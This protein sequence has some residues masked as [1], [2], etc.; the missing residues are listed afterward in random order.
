VSRAYRAEH[1]TCDEA[2]CDRP[3]RHTHHLDGRGPEGPR[4]FDPDNLL[5][6]CA[7]HNARR[8]QPWLY[9]QDEEL[10]LSLYAARGTRPAEPE[11]RRSGR[12]IFS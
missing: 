10:R 6:L 7:S 1:P 5:A 3:S 12:A 11:A 4:G 8:T 9:A 2:G